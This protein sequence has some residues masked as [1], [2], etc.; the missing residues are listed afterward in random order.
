MQTQAPKLV[1]QLAPDLRLVHLWHAMHPP[2]ASS[3][4]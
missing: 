3:I 4:P 2:D 1:T